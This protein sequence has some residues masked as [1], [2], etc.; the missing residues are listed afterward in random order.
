VGEEMSERITKEVRVNR[1]DDPG[2]VAEQ[3]AE[4]LNEFGIQC[5]NTTP[6]SEETLVYKIEVDVEVMEF[7]PDEHE[8]THHCHDPNCK[9][10]H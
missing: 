6:D 1:K 5:V 3:F 8:Q 7:D 2:I 10:D 4:I 9:H